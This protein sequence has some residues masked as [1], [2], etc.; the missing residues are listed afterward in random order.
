MSVSSDAELRE[1]LGLQTVAV[2]GCSSTPGE[3]A[4]D[5]PDYLI[6]RGYDVVPIN[7]DADEVFDRPAY[8]SLGAVPDDVQFDV[9][10]VFHPNDDVDAIVDT[11]VERDDAKV[12]WLQRGITAPDAVRRAERAGVHVVHGRCMR[13]EHQRLVAR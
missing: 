4:H 7:P 12:L 2:V 3:D 1:L 6:G 10:A 13:T 8:D 11:V 5:V 9:V